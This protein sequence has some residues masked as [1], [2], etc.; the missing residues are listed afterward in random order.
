MNASIIQINK[1]PK[2][3]QNQKKDPV[4][5]GSFLNFYID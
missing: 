4:N 2:I 5:E 3:N 1:K